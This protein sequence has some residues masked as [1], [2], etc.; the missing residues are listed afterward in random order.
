MDEHKIYVL[1]IDSEPKSLKRTIKIIQAN[2]LVLDFES[3]ADSD[4]A[5]LKIINSNPDIVLLEYPTKGKAGNE[6]IK[7]I[8]TKLTETTI[9]YV[10]KSKEYA[11]N[12]IR[13]GVFNY[14]LNPISKVELEIIINK[15]ALIKQNNIQAR[16]SQI[17]EKFPEEKRLR[18]RTTRGYL[19][20]DPEEILFCKSDG[21]YTELYLTNSRIE[22]SFLFLS[23][24]DEILSKFN[25]IRVSRSYLINRKYIRKLYRG[26]NTICLS[27]EGKEYE[28][29]SSKQH[30]RNLSNFDTE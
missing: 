12:A 1:I 19:I 5:L 25:F 22:Y 3:A 10:S 14:L 24:L 13:N 16:I 26:S 15:V 8:K 7:F 21:M 9:V 28:I 29:K 23:K 18:F 6:L 30:I 27:A 2:A 17:I 11:E 4:E 20:I